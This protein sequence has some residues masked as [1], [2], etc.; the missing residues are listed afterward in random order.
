MCTHTNTHT[1]THKH[2]HTHIHIHTEH[3]HTCTHA[4][5]HACTHACTQACTHTHARTHAGARAHTCTHRG[6]INTQMHAWHSVCKFCF[7]SVYALKPRTESS[8]NRKTLFFI[9]DNPAVDFD[10]SKS[11]DVF[12]DK[13]SVISVVMYVCTYQFLLYTCV[14]INIPF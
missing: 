11:R 10:S 6:H 14:L 8:V 2:T 3:T 13:L 1:H 9:A 7:Y 12:W 4:R 5:T